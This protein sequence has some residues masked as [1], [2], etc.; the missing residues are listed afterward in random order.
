MLINEEDK[1]V[2]GKIYSLFKRF[3]IQELTNIKFT[4][5]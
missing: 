1:R 3:I 4:S 2:T 5:L